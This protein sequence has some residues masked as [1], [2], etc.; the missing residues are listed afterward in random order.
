MKEGDK[1]LWTQHSLPPF[2]GLSTSGSARDSF[3]NHHGCL[4]WHCFLPHFLRHLLHT[5]LLSPYQ[6]ASDRSVV[7]LSLQP[8]PGNGP[9]LLSLIAHHDRE[10]RGPPT[11]TAL[12]NCGF[13]ILGSACGGG[14]STI[15]AFLCYRFLLVLHIRRHVKFCLPRLTLSS[16]FP[17][18]HFSTH[19]PCCALS[20]VPDNYPCFAFL[21]YN[22]V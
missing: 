7:I 18:L 14:G 20:S 4:L 16:I 6:C 8:H 15:S 5:L 21:F 19:C 1:V 3:S 9:W 12:S 2:L 10:E 11:A 13:R 22:A 17:R